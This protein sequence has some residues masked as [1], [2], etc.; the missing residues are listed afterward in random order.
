[1]NHKKLAQKKAPVIGKS[2]FPAISFDAFSVSFP[3][4]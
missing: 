2:L 1:M 3:H 4:S